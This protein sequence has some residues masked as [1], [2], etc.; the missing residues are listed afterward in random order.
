M[1]TRYYFIQD[2]LTELRLAQSAIETGARCGD[3]DV[4][5]DFRS[6]VAETLRYRAEGGLV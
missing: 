4:P 5:Y 6:D 3:L 2:V 1:G